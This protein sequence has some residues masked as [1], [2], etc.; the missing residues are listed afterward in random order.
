MSNVYPLNPW[1]RRNAGA[2]STNPTGTPMRRTLGASD[3]AMLTSSDCAAQFDAF[4]SANSADYATKDLARAAFAGQN[5]SCAAWATSVG[6]AAPAAPTEEQCSSLW[7]AFAAQPAN[8]GRDRASLLALFASVYPTCQAWATTQLE[9]LR[10]SS[11]NPI[12]SIVGPT[13]TPTEALSQLGLTCQQWALMTSAQQTAAL[14]PIVPTPA[15]G[16]REAAIASL[17]ARTS[18]VCASTLG[19]S[20]GGASSSSSPMLLLGGLALA[21]LLLGSGKAKL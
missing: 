4:W 15:T 3:V 16:T 17:S 8:V 7:V 14:D 18:A 9:A 21:A 12:L 13:P 20:P 1:A 2:I 19:V 11:V 10:R 6:T 5:P